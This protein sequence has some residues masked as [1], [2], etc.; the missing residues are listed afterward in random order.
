MKKVIY[1]RDE[2][3]KYTDDNCDAF[4]VKVKKMFRNVNKKLNDIKE[5]E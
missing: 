4:I 2:L 1:L 3:D 5:L